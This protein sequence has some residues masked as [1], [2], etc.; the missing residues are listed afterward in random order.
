MDKFFQAGLVFFVR[1]S[2]SRC[3]SD[4]R[5]FFVFSS[6]SSRFGVVVFWGWVFFFVGHDVILSQFLP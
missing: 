6:F 2:S 4:S 5:N 3:G 1:S